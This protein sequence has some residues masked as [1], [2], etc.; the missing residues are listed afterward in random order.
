LDPA[1]AVAVDVAGRGGGPEA[2]AREAR[3]EALCKAARD[4]GATAVLLGH[5]RDDQAETVLLAL[6]RGGGPRGLAGLPYRREV[7][8]IS[9]VRPLLEVRR[10]DTRAACVALGL[11]PWDDPHNT[12]AAYAR[13]RVRAAMPVL[14]ST[15]GAGIVDN[16]A[17]VAALTAAD[18]A[19]LDTLAAQVDADDGEG[20]RV[21]AL[22]GQP[23]AIRTRVLRAFAARVGANALS[24]RHID[25]LDALVTAWHGQGPVALPGGVTV[26]RR[27]GRLISPG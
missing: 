24:Q 18:T 5:T 14:A 7:D 19:A 12:D 11:E 22:V 9:F 3:Y 23:A 25:A 20:L 4:T 13:S 1:L 26:T 27:S 15:L 16:L 8:G 17:R 2:A 6:A 21:D 10:A